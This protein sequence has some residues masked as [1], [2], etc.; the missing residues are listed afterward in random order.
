[1][2]AHSDGGIT[3]DGRLGKIQ[4]AVSKVSVVTQPIYDGTAL[5]I[6]WL[7]RD[8]AKKRKTVP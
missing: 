1:M 3:R 4:G 7:L 5:G 2:A 8:T 6:A